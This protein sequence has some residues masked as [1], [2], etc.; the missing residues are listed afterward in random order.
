M[1]GNNSIAAV[2]YIPEFK[3]RIQIIIPFGKKAFGNKIH[4]TVRRT[5]LL[6]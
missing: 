3:S 4:T 6:L 2:Q 5:L 1:E